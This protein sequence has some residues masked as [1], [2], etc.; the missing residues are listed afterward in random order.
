MNDSKFEIGN[1]IALT[2]APHEKLRIAGVL[3]RGSDITPRF[4]YRVENYAGY[5]VDRIPEQSL[6]PHTN[7]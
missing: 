3:D 4:F 1:E 5:T 7:D 2:T 6:I